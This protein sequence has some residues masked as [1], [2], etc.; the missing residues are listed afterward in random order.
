MSKKL[1]AQPP[2]PIRLQEAR[3]KMGISQ[4]TLGILAGIDQFAASARMNQYEKGKH[5]PDY[6]TARR[7]AE[8]LG[9][10][11][12]YLYEEDDEIAA[13]LMMF[14]NLDNLGRKQ[15]MEKMAAI[16]HKQ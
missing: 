5:S 2:L 3:Q 1:E 8:V 11:C 10:P 13:M 6:A 14:Y 4:K 15:I 7:L 12:S 9:I 16:Q